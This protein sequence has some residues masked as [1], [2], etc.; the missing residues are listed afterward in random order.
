MTGSQRHQLTGP[1]GRKS[2]VGKNFLESAYGYKQ[3]SSRSKSMSAL[4]PG[5]DI[6]RLTLDFRV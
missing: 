3:T 6:P 1:E 4:P 5:P 2:F